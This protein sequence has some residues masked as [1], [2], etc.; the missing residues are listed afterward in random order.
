MNKQEQAMPESF[1]KALQELDEKY[2]Y[3]SRV[4]AEYIWNAAHSHLL[5][6]L[7]EARD[8][9]EKCRPFQIC[10]ELEDIIRPALLTINA[11]LGE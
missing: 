10:T 1:N 8:A 7:T 2:G 4:H 5:P 11:A 3:V 6:A 9:L